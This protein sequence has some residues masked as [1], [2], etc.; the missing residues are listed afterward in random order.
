MKIGLKTCFMSSAFR[1]C[2]SIIM[3]ICMVVLLLPNQQEV[4]SSE[5]TNDW[6]GAYTKTEYTISSFE[7]LCFFADAVNNGLDFSGKTVKLTND[8]TIS[9][10]YTP[11]GNPRGSIGFRGVFDGAGHTIQWES[12]AEVSNFGIIGYNLGTITNVTVTGTVT[13]SAITA[14]GGIAGYNAGEIRGC[15]NL[16]LLNIPNADFIGGIAGLNEGMI[17]N[18]INSGSINGNMGAGGIAGKSANGGVIK[19]SFNA[20]SIYAV[21]ESAGGIA[22][23]NAINDGGLIE[24]CFNKGNAAAGSRYAGGI[25]GCNHE[26]II[27]NSYNIAQ[28]L[29]AGISGHNAYNASK[30]EN[31]YSICDPVVGDKKGVQDNVFC[32]AVNNNAE[33]IMNQLNE[34]VKLKGKS[35]DLPW[36]IGSNGYPVLANRIGVTI[37]CEGIKASMS[38]T[39]KDWL[40]ASQFSAADLEWNGRSK[41]ADIVLSVKKMEQSTVLESQKKIVD[42]YI[43]GAKLDSCDSTYLDITLTKIG[44]VSAPITSTAPQNIEITLSELDGSKQYQILRLNESQGEEGAVYLPDK[45]SDT[46]S[47]TLETNHFST[48]VLLMQKE[49]TGN[50]NLNDYEYIWQKVKED[51]VEEKKE[52]KTEEEKAEEEK[53]EEEKTEEEKTETETEE[54]FEELAGEEVDMALELIEEETEED[55]DNNAENEEAIVPSS[56]PARK[57]APDKSAE[58]EL[59]NIPRT[60]EDRSKNTAA[61]VGMAAL[62]FYLLSKRLNTL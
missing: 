44:N 18:C 47:Y 27:R 49:K 1:F 40:I 33:D 6:V 36:C 15:T 46:G 24:N 32:G 51:P 58:R 8:I 35:D 43:E 53:A 41:N 9:G 7:E 21:T 42:K 28:G 57:P 62:M 23:V 5:V 60:G 50:N 37:V 26:G 20:G 16:S 2:M 25:A 56:K 30:I 61:F 14:A 4:F 3:S 17:Q 11:A 19:E 55:I 12:G 13:G 29:S 45:D 48:Y 52:E 34:W 22:G 59:D 39:S 54:T 10:A 31:C 38:D